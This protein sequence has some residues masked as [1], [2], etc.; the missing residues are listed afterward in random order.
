MSI[1]IN[2]PTKGTKFQLGNTVEFKGT[3]SSDITTVKLLAE[4]K[5]PLGEAK[6]SSGIWEVSAKFNTKGD[7][8]IVAQG[9]NIAGNLVE[10]TEITI[11]LQ[12]SIV[13][14]VLA[15]DLA[16]PESAVRVKTLTLWATHYRVHRAK[17]RPSG[18]PLL[19]IAG[20]HLGPKLSNRDWCQAALQ[21]TV[22]VLDEKGTPKTFNFAGRGSAMQVDCSSFFPSLS[23]SVIQGTNRVRFAVSKGPYGE[24][25]DGLILVPYRTVAVDRTVIPIGSLIYIPA[26]RG[27]K[28]ILPSGES[29]EHDGYF[30]AADVGGA[31]NNNHIDVFLGISQQ[32]PFSFIQSKASSTF[33]AFLI[34]DAKALESIKLLHLLSDK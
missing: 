17:N 6:V 2:S 24:G 7:R 34:N 19:D 22:Q 29:I 18:N 32:N 3:I 9:F 8:R 4:N 13:S 10:T 21:G 12:D 27:Q 20:N 16:E 15:F 31:I 1:K 28:I 5:W 25:V 23:S 33:T 11:I 14:K 30:Y 26:A